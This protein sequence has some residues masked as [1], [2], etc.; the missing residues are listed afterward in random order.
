MSLLTTSALMQFFGWAT[1]INFLIL[2]VAT[3]SIVLMRDTMI[4]IHSKMFGI[5]KNQLPAMYF[6]YLA[7]YKIATVVFCFVPWLALTII[8]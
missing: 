2:A 6:R 3:L 8:S 1:L 5:E 4:D 7:N